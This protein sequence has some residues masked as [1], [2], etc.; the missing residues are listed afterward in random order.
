VH[1]IR[2]LVRPNDALEPLGVLVR[3]LAVVDVGSNTVRLVVFE[4]P[5]GGSPR[6]IAEGKEVPRLGEGVGHGGR[7]AP[8]AMDRAVASLGR[9]A[10]T[11]E[12]LGR[13]PT[14]AVATSAVREAANGAEF[15]R[16]ASD[17][18]GLALRILT[19]LDEARY[20]YLGVASAWELG[21]DRVCDLGGGSLQV[22]AV[23]AGT[24]KSAVSLPLGALRLTEEFLAHDP[25]K[26]REIEELRQHVREFLAGPMRGEAD[27]SGFEIHGV[28]GTIRC[29]ARV[30]I[31]A[32]AYPLARVHGY[33]LRRRDLE[34]LAELLPGLPAEKRRDVAGI[35]GERADVIVAGLFT[36][37]EL[38]R[39]SGRAYLRVSGMGIR[40]GIAAEALGLPIPV[41][42][43]VLLRRS[44]MTTARAFGSP[45]RREEALARRAL[46][47]FELLGRSEGWGPTERRSLL[48]TALLHDAGASIDLWGHARHAAYLIEN[49]PLVGLTHLE[50]VRAA[51]IAFQHEGDD[52]GDAFRKEL[53]ALLEKD[54]VRSARRLG[55]LVLAAET[56]DDPDV[57]LARGGDGAIVVTLSREGARTLSPRALGRVRKTL[58]RTFGVEVEVRGARE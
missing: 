12:R 52:P 8:A 38:L 48:A 2:P 44:A 49:A 39:A 31:A 3:R 42:S 1:G 27:R 53:R 36:V 13:P 24:L 9:F 22:A 51:L 5:E 17:E 45:F 58:K 47:L 41:P 14:I 28:G 37:L 29:L 20:S 6:A 33:P 11:L 7:L 43:E 57:G 46:A 56:L 30:A 34:A 26:D 21:D 16:R 19:G 4:A 40:E 55:A 10:A 18:T 15:L 32:R 35:S 54:E 25:P 50:I 23:E